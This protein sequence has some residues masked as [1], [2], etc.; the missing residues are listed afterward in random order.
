[1]QNFGEEISLNAV[2]LKTEKD[3]AGVH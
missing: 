1:M 3:V 2:A